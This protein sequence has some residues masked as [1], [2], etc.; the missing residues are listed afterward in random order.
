MGTKAA[1]SCRIAAARARTNCC[2]EDLMT[3]SK[4]PLAFLLCGSA[5]TCATWSS[6]MPSKG[7]IEL[8]ARFR[9]QLP[10]ASNQLYYVLERVR[11]MR[12][13]LRLQSDSP[14]LPRAHVLHYEH[15]LM[16]TPA[17]FRGLGGTIY[18]LGGSSVIDPRGHDFAFVLG[19]VRGVSPL[20]LRAGRPARESLGRRR[21]SEARQSFSM[22]G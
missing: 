4:A 14:D 8:N 7:A 9:V 22:P 16:G 2:L 13:A 20:P 3:A 19:S 5:T 1:Q 11:R 10:W 21:R 17:I 6:A 15:V 12:G 18:Q